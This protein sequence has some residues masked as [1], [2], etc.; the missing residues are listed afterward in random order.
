MLAG[1]VVVEDS[2]SHPLGRKNEKTTPLHDA[3]LSAVDSLMYIR[4]VCQ[5]IILFP[6][7]GFMKPF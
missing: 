6:L 1:E 4:Q 7:R 5:Y 3:V 2:S